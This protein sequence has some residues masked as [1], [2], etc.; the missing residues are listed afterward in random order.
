MSSAWPVGMTPSRSPSSPMTRTSRARIRSLR[1]SSRAML[2]PSW[3][4]AVSPSLQGLTIAECLTASQRNI[5]LIECSVFPHRL[6]NLEQHQERRTL[7]DALANGHIDG[8]D[9][10]RTPGVQVVLH[11]H[12]LD[13]EDDLPGFDLIAGLDTHVL[14]DAPHRGAEHP[15]AR[16]EEHTSE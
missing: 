9:G 1:R 4:V 15:F 16:S 5:F 11:L 8:L 12:R 13:D 14:N 10:P 2:A 3:Q 6:P 7:F